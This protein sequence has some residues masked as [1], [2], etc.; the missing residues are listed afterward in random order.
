MLVNNRE[1][2]TFLYYSDSDNINQIPELSGN[3]YFVHYINIDSKLGVNESWKALKNFSSVDFDNSEEGK[4]QKYFYKVRE[5]SFKD[6]NPNSVLGLKAER[7][8]TLFEYL[9]SSNLNLNK[10]L[11]YYRDLCFTRP[12]YIGKAQNLRSRISQHVRGSS[13]ILK[14]IDSHSIDKDCIWISFEIIDQEA[15]EI[16]NIYEEIAQ[17][18]L[19]PSIT[20]KFG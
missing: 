11:S 20:E 3:Y 8:T 13:N 17:K 14:E 6:Y 18:F 12:F 9:S 5:L 16:L 10:F 2:K 1:Y 7:A 4:G 19:K 15:P